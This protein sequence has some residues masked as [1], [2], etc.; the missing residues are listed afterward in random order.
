MNHV[1]DKAHSPSLESSVRSTCRPPAIFYT[2]PSSCARQA[3]AN[4]PT[5][6]SD[7]RKRSG[8]SSSSQCAASVSSKGARLRRKRFLE[9]AEFSFLFPQHLLGSRDIFPLTRGSR[10][11]ARRARG[12]PHVRA[13][14]QLA[15][16]QSAQERFTD[17]DH[18]FCLLCAV[19]VGLACHPSTGFSTPF[20]EPFQLGSVTTLEPCESGVTFL[21]QSMDHPRAP[22]LSPARDTILSFLH[23]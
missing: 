8:T 13:T 15:P 9:L 6:V 11:R 22:S 1:P 17:R 19:L 16:E 20:F 14:P 23:R 18:R 12:T 3:R 10:S 4:L 2:F 5:V 21:M 7:F